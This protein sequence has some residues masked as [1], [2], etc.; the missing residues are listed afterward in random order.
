MAT[1]RVIVVTGASSGIGRATAIGLS[2]AFPSPANPEPLVLVL[3]GRREAELK[4]T[5]DACREGTTVEIQIADVS[6][7][8]QV[9][10]VFETVKS[11]Y[12]RLDVLF[13]VGRRTW[14]PQREQEC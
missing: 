14:E 11:K 9:S 8:A 13:N 4:E 6:V 2:E 12:G 5:A 7:D 1:S 3:V 10:T